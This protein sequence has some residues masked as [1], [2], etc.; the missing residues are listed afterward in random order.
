LKKVALVF[1]RR[2]LWT[3]TDSGGKPK[4][5]FEDDASTRL[6][7]PTMLPDGRTV[8]FTVASLGNWEQAHIDAINLT[9]EQRKT[10]LTNAADARYSPTGYLVFMRN[11]ALLAV[12]F[13][14]ARVEVTGAPVPL[15]A[16]I[17][18]STNAPNPNEETGMGQLRLSA[19]GML[20]F[21]SGD[22]YPT[23]AS[24]LVQVNRKG[25]ESKLAESKGALLGLRLSSSGSRVV[26]F[27]GGD[28]TFA[29]DLW[30]YELP[31]GAAA[32]LTS[33]G[34]VSSPLFSPDGK[35][36][37]FV[38]AGSSP[39]IYSL[40]LN[41]N[42]ATQRVS[43]GKPGLV[44]ASYSPD[45]KWLAY[46]QT[47]GSVP[48]I[49]VRPVR[50]P[51]LDIGEPRQFSPSTFTQ[52][53]AEF[54]P[55]S[56]WIDYTSSESGALEVYVQPFPGPGE[57]HRISS[58]GGTNPAWSRNGREL[59]YVVPAPRAPARSWMAVDFSTTGDF[60]VSAPRL[61]FEGPYAVTTTLRS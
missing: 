51:K 50:D 42:T 46:L 14:T 25:S 9:T 35:S 41:G 3:V 37:T 1:A 7:S 18:Q 26:A 24:T 28:G 56:R 15:L 19:S 47:V 39:G 59:F 13:D 20:V 60:K 21:A 17:M 31:S 8:L 36:V 49:F 33:T 53:Q 57:K 10:L 23:L 2:G 54:S 22:R 34:D 58:R 11:A 6:F 29:T 5:A 30:L 55:D 61:L 52:Q 44:A 12:P 45:G 27:Q 16:G 40:P 4:A 32:R 43:E 48:Q 38:R